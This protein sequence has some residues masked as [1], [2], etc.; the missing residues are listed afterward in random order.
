[1]TE[2][3]SPRVVTADQWKRLKR[4]SHRKPVFALMGE[5]SA[6]K[7]TLLNFLL[8][9][10]TLPTQVTAT[11]LPPIWFSWGNKPAYVQKL[12]GSR[13]EIDLAKIGEIGVQGAH[14]VRIYLEAEILEAVDLIDTPGIS[15]PKISSDV[16]QRAVGQ[17]NGVLWCTHATQ[18]WR[19]TERA[20]WASLPKRL[21]QNSI[22]LVTRADALKETD[23]NKVLRRINREAGDMFRNMISIS[24]RDAILARDNPEHANLWESSGG[25]KLVDN[26]LE[27]T[28]DIMQARATMLARYQADGT[29]AQPESN[30]LQLGGETSTRVWAAPVLSTTE[31]PQVAA[32]PEPT[33]AP[34]PT[35]ASPAIRQPIHARAPEATPEPTAAASVQASEPVVTHEPAPGPAPAPAAESAPQADG[36]VVS[37]RPARP[38]RTLQTRDVSSSRQRID[39]DEADKL[40]AQVHADNQEDHDLQGLKSVFDM[41]STPEEPTPAVEVDPIQE[42]VELV[43]EVASAPEVVEVAAE[44]DTDDAAEVDLGLPSAL[45]GIRAALDSSEVEPATPA[46]EPAPEPTPEVAEQSDATGDILPDL[47]AALAQETAADDTPAEPEVATAAPPVPHDE[48]GLLTSIGGLMSDTAETEPANDDVIEPASTS[49][50]AEPIALPPASTL[51]SMPDTDPLSAADAWAEHLSTLEHIHDPSALLNAFQEFLTR[52]DMRARAH[53]EKQSEGALEALSGAGADSDTVWH[54][55]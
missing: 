28:A 20:T 3:N 35:P 14:F 7:S 30:A 8:K 34:A 45:A 2:Q 38:R 11:Q 33:P 27:I 25:G 47:R 46:P 32:T 12:D 19:E 13:E 10:N 51:F 5:F 43:D 41:P 6:G 4:W 40:R 36:N 17:A 44:A 18:A 52:F 29:N 15:D 39:A 53:H 49:A 42:A 24:A 26:F 55:L 9:R 1:M 31:E 50:T 23:R 16:W 48:N 37:I 21:R 54:V 22:L